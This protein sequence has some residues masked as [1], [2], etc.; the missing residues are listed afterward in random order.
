M[1]VVSTVI[2]SV[3]VFVDPILIPVQ[4]VIGA[5]ATSMCYN[6]YI[7]PPRVAVIIRPLAL[8]LTRP[9]TGFRAG[10]PRGGGNENCCGYYSVFCTQQN[11]QTQ[12]KL[13]IDS[14]TV[15]FRSKTTRNVVVVLSP[16]LTLTIWTSTVQW[17]GIR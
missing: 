3:F 6:Y 12:M 11:K 4:S 1:C 5:K 7:V 9:K 16:K 17:P 10:M 2:I 14:C 15:A 8:L 13:K